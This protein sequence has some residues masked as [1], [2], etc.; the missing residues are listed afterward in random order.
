MEKFSELKKGHIG[1]IEKGTGNKLGFGCVPMCY[2]YFTVDISRNVKT[3][4][5]NTISTLIVTI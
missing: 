1:I 2:M 4:P 3:S 5:H